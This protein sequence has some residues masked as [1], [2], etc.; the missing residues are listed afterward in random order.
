MD[1]KEKALLMTPCEVCEMLGQK[2][3]CRPEDDCYTCG[4][5]AEIMFA[6][7][8]ATCRLIRERT[9]KKKWPLPRCRATEAKMKG[10]YVGFYYKPERNLCQV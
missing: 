1:I 3:G 7:W 8:D 2:R 9:G 4:I 10:H 6:Q 5:Y